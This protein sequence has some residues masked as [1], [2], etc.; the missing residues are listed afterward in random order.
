MILLAII[1]L[2]VAHYFYVRIYWIKRFE[3]VVLQRSPSLF[4]HLP[5]FAYMVFRH[6]FEWNE[7]AFLPNITDLRI[8]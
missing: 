3:L 1:V 7:T 5:T 2:L 8:E 4:T 6:P